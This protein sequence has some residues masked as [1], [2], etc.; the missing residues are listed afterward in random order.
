[1]MRI[2][3][4]TAAM[5]LGVG[6]CL[7]EVVQLQQ[8]KDGYAGCAAR[9]IE[10][11]GPSKDLKDSTIFPLRGSRYAL[12]VKFDLPAGL[13]QKKLTRA[14]L[15]VFLPEA[16]KPNYF[17]EIFCHE[18]MTSGRQPTWDELT[19][20]N[21]GRRR[22][23]VDSVE[24]FAPPHEGWPSFPFL[25][26]GVPPGGRW[27]EFNVTPLAEGWLKA[28]TDA[29]GMIVNNGV[30]LLPT[31]P[32]DRNKT[33]TWEIDIPI[34]GTG[35]TTGTTGVSPVSSNPAGGTPATRTGGTPVLPRL[36]LEFAPL[37]QDVLV[38]VTDSLT[39]ICDRSTRYAYR[40]DYST[41]AKLSMAKDEFEG[42]QLAIYPVTADVKNLR[43]AWGDLKGEDGKSIPAADIECF[44]EDVFQLRR[45]WMTSGLMFAGKLY[46]VPD[47]LRPWPNSSAKGGS[48]DGGGSYASTTTGPGDTSN[49]AYG[50]LGVWAAATRAAQG[51]CP[52]HQ[53]RPFYFRVRTRPETA[54]GTYKGAITIAAD[55]LKSVTVN[56]EVKVW[57][58]ALPRTWNFHTMGQ[59]IWGN[60]QKWHGEG[61]TKD[62]QREYYD[63]LL[64]HRFAPTEQ[65]GK[66]LSPRQDM[67]H[68]LARGMNTIYLNGNFTGTEAEVAELKTRV[69]QVRKLSGL[70]YAL[71]YIGDETDKW[72]EM[73]RL[74]DLV[75]AHLPG[76]QVM[77]G[78]S[79]PRPELTGYIDVYDPDIGGGS[80]VFSLDEDKIGLIKESQQRG[81]EFYWYVA[82]G[83]SY[84]K[85]NVQNEFPL[86]D[87]RTI[88]WMTW[89]YGVTGFEYYCYN[90]W[91]QL[92]REPRWPGGPLVADGWSKGWPS[93]GDGMI[94]YPGPTTSLR[95][96]SIRDGIE[97]WESLQVLR[98]CV[99]AVR[100][101]KNQGR[102]KD[103]IAQA[104]GLLK[105]SDEV[106]K[107]FAEFTRDP[108]RLMAERERL[109]EL[110][111]R[112]VPLV[113]KLEEYD[114][115]QMN[116]VK[117]AEARI[118]KQTARR[119]AMLFDRHVKASAALKA[120]PLA[121][122]QF[123]EH[124][125][126]RVLFAQDFEQGIDKCGGA[127][128]TQNLPPGSKG[129]LAGDS[130]NTYY[131]RFARVGIRFDNA[132]AATTTWLTFKYFLSKDTPITV[133]TFDLTQGD[134]FVG[135]LAKPEAGK[136]TE[137]T[138]K[139]SD[140][141]KKD[142]SAKKI[143]A[144]NAI[145]DIFFGAGKPGENLQLIIDDVRLIGRD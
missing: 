20:Y 46:D 109:G 19:D 34:S 39:R 119:R 76:A 130:K 69:E 127:H 64:D 90:I 122:G 35:T 14:R 143:T 77:I 2:M 65:Y 88:F 138:M 3:A 31:D 141:T 145:D 29:K 23:A 62:K 12:H 13:A 73:R 60:A 66:I 91:E 30:I 1:M 81:E 37:E 15:A 87:C 103:L 16:R 106:V 21:N 68:C 55:K 7:G 82:A 102:Y 27:I 79:F 48:A 144:G 70:D 110:L 123:D 59:F 33:S 124:W 61:W 40:G 85:P 52:R 114:A 57:P 43:I 125:P 136:W 28:Q 5:A 142:G 80:K 139:V 10:G 17:T 63:F 131:A 44:G 8:G 92:Y 58:Y 36:V 51:D 98:D 108:K 104:E 26:L 22:G 84:P 72:G 75:H 4:M 95:F 128:E 126:K 93:N 97:D 45:N 129:A 140:F 32:P 120:A 111:A 113:E 135:T 6:A 18:V 41:D 112:F 101:R 53:H 134:N 96:E 11:T 47:A 50:A 9:V 24:L 133:M 42:F 78:G 83:P 54:A 74:A 67:E 89:K 38:G 86:I 94:F 107:G 132:R 100:Q 121:R 116:L 71:V 49:S 115:G 25:P 137:A 99:E 56:V 117:A 105:V 118:A